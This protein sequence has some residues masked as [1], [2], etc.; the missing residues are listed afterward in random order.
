MPKPDVREG[1]FRDK[2]LE[3]MHQF[4]DLF[5][6]LI[7]LGI[8]NGEFRPVNTRDT[9]MVASAQLE[10]LLL[11]WAINREAVDLTVMTKTAVDLLLRGLSA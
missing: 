2:M 4:I 10:G 9:A 8:D 3:Y 1:A 7:Q 11:Y 5:A 6:A